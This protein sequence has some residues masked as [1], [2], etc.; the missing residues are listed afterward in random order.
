MDDRYALEIINR[1][2]DVNGNLI[3]VETAIEKL[4]T[5]IEEKFTGTKKEPEL[6]SSVKPKITRKRIHATS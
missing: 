5:V 3:D 6:S 2:D 1:L 4:I